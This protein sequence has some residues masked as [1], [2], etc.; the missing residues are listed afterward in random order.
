MLGY[1][2]LWDLQDKDIWQEGGMGI[3]PSPSGHIRPSSGQFSGMDLNEGRR[4]E[5]RPHLATTRDKRPTH[6]P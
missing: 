6:H 1:R 2:G 5:F 4:Q 3:S